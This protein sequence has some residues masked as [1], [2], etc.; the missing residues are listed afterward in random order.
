MVIAVHSCIL[1]AG[2]HIT[3]PVIAM[4][5]GEVIAD[6][7]DPD[8]ILYTDAAGYVFLVLLMLRGSHVSTRGACIF[9]NERLIPIK[10]AVDR[11]CV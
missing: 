2:Y 9:K 7:A 3:Q 8:A 11:W 4:A 5:I 10:M 1:V 6:D